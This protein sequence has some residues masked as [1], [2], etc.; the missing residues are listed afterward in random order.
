M[1]FQE[2][3]FSQYTQFSRNALKYII[4]TKV[5]DGPSVVE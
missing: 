2:S 3:D 5:G 1:S 4:H